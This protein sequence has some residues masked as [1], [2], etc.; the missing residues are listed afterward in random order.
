ME[1][2]LSIEE[3]QK[4]AYDAVLLPGGD[5]TPLLR[6]YTPLLELL[7]NF[8]ER[9]K[10]IGALCWAPT[11]LAEAGFLKGAKVAV[12][13]IPD[14]GKYEGMRSEE[15]VV[16]AGAGIAGT[17]VARWGHIL[18]ASGPRKAEEFADEFARILK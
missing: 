15:V 11:I 7:R 12:C 18:T 1:V 10:P 3:V 8:F 14:Q 9:E 5:G 17:G 16:A 13:H 6:E 4:E 2:S